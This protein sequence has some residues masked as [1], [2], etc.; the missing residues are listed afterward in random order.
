[1]VLSSLIKDKI[2]GSGSAYAN[3]DPYIKSIF[4]HSNLATQAEDRYRNGDI[5]SIRTHLNWVTY[6]YRE[7]SPFIKTVKKEEKKEEINFRDD[8]EKDLYNFEKEIKEILQSQIKRGTTNIN[9][10]RI[11]EDK[12]NSLDEINWK[13]S[14]IHRELFEIA[15]QQGLFV[16]WKSKP[17][18][19]TK[20][21]K[22]L[23]DAAMG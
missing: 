2:S 5:N 12:R 7:L 20:G 15:C 19:R 18:N 9:P 10:R 11:N 21:Y 13:I 3:T 22:V 4:E 6:L 14:R 17:E 8:Y 23:E 16:S 1:M